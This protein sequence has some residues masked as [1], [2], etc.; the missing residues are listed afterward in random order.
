VDLAT[1]TATTQITGQSTIKKQQLA[2]VSVDI[3]G[4]SAG[5]A[6]SIDLTLT[7]DSD[8]PFTITG[9]DS[10]NFAPSTNGIAPTKNAG[11]IGIKIPCDAP[12]GTYSAQVTVHTVDL[13]GNAWTDITPPNL[14]FTI[15]PAI[16][17]ESETLVVAETTGGD[18][19]NV[20]TF[21]AVQAK[22]SINTNPGSFHIAEI[23][24][25]GGACLGEETVGGI[26]AILQIPTG[27]SYLT[28]GASPIVHVFE[29][30]GTVL[31]LH[32][33][34]DFVEVTSLVSQTSPNAGSITLDLSALGEVPAD[35]T[36]Y[37]RAHIKFSA[38]SV[39]AP[40]TSYTFNS[41]DSVATVDSVS[42]PLTN[43][44]SYVLT[45]NPN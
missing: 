33:P 32:T 21:T 8:P 14:S 18:Y 2:K 22:K 26:G 4:G 30:T 19:D 13:A 20:T 6:F 17:L 15:E 12:L 43:S 42:F 27:F 25:F 3:V 34:T 9:S 5:T 24:T 40:N 35:T 45:A 29:G 39:P 41:S 38:T 7:S 1:P 31:D 44:S 28:T 16:A 11:P 10:G 36:I 23:I 37:I